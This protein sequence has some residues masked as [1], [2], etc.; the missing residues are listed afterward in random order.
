MG[1]TLTVLESNYCT[2]TIP[3]K[4]DEESIL[5]QVI[6]NIALQLNTSETLLWHPLAVTTSSFLTQSAVAHPEVDKVQDDLPNHGR[7]DALPGEAKALAEHEHKDR[8]RQHREPCAVDFI[9]SRQQSGQQD[10]G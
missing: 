3:N 9:A 2:A 10:N 4:F 1:V 6:F 8:P 5:F 7:H